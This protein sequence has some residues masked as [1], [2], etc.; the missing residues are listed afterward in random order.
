MLCRPLA[1]RD[2]V[3]LSPLSSL[4]PPSFRGQVTYG[5]MPWAGMSPGD[6]IGTWPN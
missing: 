1:L 4:H 3:L 6:I 5:A 2:F